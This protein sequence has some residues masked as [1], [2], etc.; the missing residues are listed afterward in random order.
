MAALALVPPFHLASD[1]GLPCLISWSASRYSGKCRPVLPLE[2]G[3]GA[4]V[5][6]GGGAGSTSSLFAAPF[7]FQAPLGW[8]L[9]GGRLQSCR[10]GLCALLMACGSRLDARHGIA[11]HFGRHHLQAHPLAMSLNVAKCNLS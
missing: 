10:G 4:C 9:G 5:S 11:A 1:S 3:V 8:S 6:L 2:L 7:A